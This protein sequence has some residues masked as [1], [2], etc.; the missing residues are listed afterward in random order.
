M[1]QLPANTRRK[2][3]LCSPVWDN[4]TATGEPCFLCGPSWDIINRTIY[5]FKYGICAICTLDKAKHI[6]KLT[7]KL[8]SVALVRK[9]NIPTERPPLFIS[10]KNP[11][12]HRRGCIR[13]DYDCKVSVK[14]KSVHEPQG[15]WCQDGLAVIHQSYSN[16]LALGQS[17]AG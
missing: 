8:N 11:F 17:S 7:K 16:E 1:V 14:K 6:H 12:S 4:S 5:W 3:F 13:K 10:Y 9:R 15:V 2:G